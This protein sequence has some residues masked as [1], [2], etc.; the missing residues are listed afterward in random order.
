MHSLLTTSL[1]LASSTAP[2]LPSGTLLDDAVLIRTFAN[3]AVTPITPMSA[4]SSGT[5]LWTVDGGSIGG[6]ELVR[7][8]PDGTL[9]A[10]LPSGFDARSIFTDS[11]GALFGKAYGGNVYSIDPNG[12][13]TLLFDLPEGNPQAS[14]SF[15]ADDTEL[16]TLSTNG[17]LRRYDATTGAALSSTP[18]LGWGVTVP[19]ETGHPDAHQLETTPTG[20]IL[21]YSDGIVSEWDL[22][23]NR[24]GTCSVPI[25]TASDFD[26]VW[27]FSVADPG[28][29]Y[30]L[31]TISD[32][33]EVYDVGTALAVNYCSPAVPNS[34]GFP[35]SI[36]ATGSP[37]AADNDLTL[38][39]EDLP[40]GEFGYFLVGSD[41]GTLAPPGSQ[42][43]LCIVC[44]GFQGCAGIGR[45]NR[46]GEIVQGPTGSLSV[47]LTALPLSPP[48]AVAP[49]DTWNFQCWYRDLGSSNFS[50][51]IAVQFL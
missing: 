4:A 22:A 40:P 1:V 15:N 42:G 14:A 29:V 45:Y 2:S 44:A 16:Y 8:L 35:A 27:S 38:L 46:S 33:W 31:N 24:I 32:E 34:T 6:S 19:S 20:R 43:I 13:A 48:V 37:L 28:F 7:Y 25:A 3:G 50:D 9:D 17:I 26:T 12:V 51:A 39:V 30:L 18:L 41:Q 47:D 10:A 21:T 23:G 11:S 49:G 36:S 5:H